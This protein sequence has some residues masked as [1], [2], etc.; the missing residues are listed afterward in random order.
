MT[1]KEVILNNDRIAYISACGGIEIHHI[2]YGI[3]DYIYFT[4]N[5]WHGKK[6]Y[7]KAKIYYDRKTP[8]FK[9]NGY[10]LKLDEAI[11]G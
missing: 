3:N 6:T 10:I 2:S 8:Y 7:H 4:S 1:K 11:R 9:H 5:A